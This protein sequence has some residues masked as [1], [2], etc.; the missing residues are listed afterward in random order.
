MENMKTVY[1]HPDGYSQSLNLSPIG[2]MPM[3]HS[4]YFRRH[5]EQ[6]FSDLRA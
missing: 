4:L 6:I 2:T 5:K 1:S 3:R